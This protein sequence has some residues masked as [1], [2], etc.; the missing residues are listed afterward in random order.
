MTSR[1]SVTIIKYRMTLSIENQVDITKCL[2]LSINNNKS[3]KHIE[4]LHW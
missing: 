2:A 4:I 3:N 1:Y